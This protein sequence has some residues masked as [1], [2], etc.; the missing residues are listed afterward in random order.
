MNVFWE[1][2]QELNDRALP[3]LDS[4][5]SRAGLD[6]YLGHERGDFG[7]QKL[8]SKFTIF[9]YHSLA[10]RAGEEITFWNKIIL[11]KILLC[12]SFSAIRVS[13]FKG[14]LVTPKRI[15]F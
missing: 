7:E 8:Y 6:H 14:S 12:H 4:L 5:A 15:H 3:N 11:I 2:R 10:S 9:N 1:G 13:T